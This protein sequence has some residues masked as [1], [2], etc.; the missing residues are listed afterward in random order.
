MRWPK[1]TIAVGFLSIALVGSSTAADLLRQVDQSACII[2]PDSRI[3]SLSDDEFRAKL[4][5]YYQLSKMEVAN[6][7]TIGSTSPRFTWALAA[8]LQCTIALGYLSTGAVDAQSAQKCDCF[9]RHMTS[10]R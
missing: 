2:S 7:S 4:E 6:T 10:F 8:K 5:E 9:T 3:M 1:L